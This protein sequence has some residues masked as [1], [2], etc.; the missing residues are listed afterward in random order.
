MGLFHLNY[1]DLSCCSFWVIFHKLSVGVMF[2][3]LSGSTFF[4]V[5][6]VMLSFVF[7][8]RLGFLAFSTFS[9]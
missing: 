3:Y 6:N 9:T 5:S 2:M 8:A 7:V 4:M 1:G